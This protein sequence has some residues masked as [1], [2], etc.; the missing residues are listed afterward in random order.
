MDLYGWKNGRITVEENESGLKK[1]I[2]K[3]SKLLEK[4]NAKLIGLALPHNQLSTNYSK[5]K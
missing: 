5:V 2:R 1:F 4:A 3:F